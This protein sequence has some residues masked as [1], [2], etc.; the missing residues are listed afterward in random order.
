MRRSIIVYFLFLTLV[1][2]HCKREHST[3]YEGHD[4]GVA[5]QSNNKILDVKYLRW[6]YDAL[7]AKAI[8][9]VLVPSNYQLDSIESVSRITSQRIFIQKDGVLK[10]VIY[11]QVTNYYLNAKQLVLYCYPSATITNAQIPALLMDL[12]YICNNIEVKFY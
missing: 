12:S 5:S 9:M 10:N 7:N 3:M 11:Y 8:S 4:T 2:V 6:Q 1:T